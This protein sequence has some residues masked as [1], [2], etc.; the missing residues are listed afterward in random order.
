MVLGHE[1]MG[2]VEE[3]GSAVTK[4][5]KGDRVVGP[6]PIACGA[7][8]FCKDGLPGDCEKSNPNHYELGGGLL[9][10]KGDGLFGYTDLYSGYSGG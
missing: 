6:F 3:T 7:C 10:E 9:G 1:F 8:F 4:L 5:A 2:V